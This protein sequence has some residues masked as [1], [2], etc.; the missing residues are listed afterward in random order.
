M[1]FS[2]RM[3]QDTTVIAIEGTLTATNRLQFRQLV[4]DEIVRGGRLFRV[5]CRDAS[6][7]DNAGLGV[8]V[9]LAKVIRARGGEIRIT[10]LNFD[11][12][13]LFE[14]TKL[15]T[16]FRLED[17]GGDGLAGQPASVKPVSPLSMGSHQPYPDEP[18][19]SRAS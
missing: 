1:A 11:L 18:G 13:T 12:R 9:S 6:Y 4:S 10:N 15:D 7:I 2:V 5:D 3:D 16:L 17:A 14:L 19:E 8:L